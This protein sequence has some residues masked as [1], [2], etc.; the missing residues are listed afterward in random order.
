[1]GLFPPS[2]IRSLRLIRDTLESKEVSGGKAW[3]VRMMGLDI[4]EFTL[5][6]VNS[7]VV[8]FPLFNWFV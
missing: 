4:M 1:M 7:K 8:Q 3:V 6:M 5:N 2:K